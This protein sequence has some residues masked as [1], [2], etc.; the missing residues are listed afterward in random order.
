M[1][2]TNRMG[3]SFLWIDALCIIQDD[4]DDLAVELSRMAQIYHH[5]LFTISASSAAAHT[6]G[7]L[8]LR[9]EDLAIPEHQ[10]LIPTVPL[11]CIFPEPDRPSAE[12][13]GTINISTREPFYQHLDE[14]ISK[15]AW[16]F[17]ERL[18]SRRVLDYCS[19]KLRWFCRGAVAVDG[20]SAEVNHQWATLPE[21]E[22]ISSLSKLERDRLWRLVV[23]RYLMRDMTFPADRLTAI[24]AVA[25]QFSGAFG[26]EYAAGLWR[27]ALV[28]QLVW[29][30][31]DA[32]L[33][34]RPEIY[35]GPSWSWAGN[36]S[37]VDITS[38]VDPAEQG[39]SEVVIVECN[40]SLAHEHAPFGAV[41]DATLVLRAR[42]RPIVW[43]YNRHEVLMPGQ[44]GRPTLRFYASRERLEASGQGGKTDFWAF[45]N[46]DALEDW[47]VN[48]EEMAE[49]S[50]WCLKLTKPT[51]K[52]PSFC[53]MLLE[54][55]GG[56]KDVYRRIGLAM[57]GSKGL[58]DIPQDREDFFEDIE[59]QMVTL[60]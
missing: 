52:K 20:G 7:F 51:L 3:L 6:D 34:E 2:V 39:E 56:K 26:G 32:Q 37:V 25:T 1:I 29:W 50:A 22:A 8:S 12:T 43:L 28:Q 54:A 46:M 11:R 42:M 14:P 33:K 30:V 41:T 45:T 59:T 5:A 38:D 21:S 57:L 24:S 40:V 49:V 4:P 9:K 44:N 13:L 60:I 47:N 15:R 16:T 27:T 17:Q 55:G 35:T 18:L 53:L 10:F 19:D 31:P 58:F 48:K 23:S 36:R